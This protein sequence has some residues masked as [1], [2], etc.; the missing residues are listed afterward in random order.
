MLDETERGWKQ[1]LYGREN[2][3]M[4]KQNLEPSIYFYNFSI[5]YIYIYIY[6]YIL[7]IPQLKHSDREV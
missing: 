6:I 1:K 3:I 2:K 4:E 7:Y 5:S